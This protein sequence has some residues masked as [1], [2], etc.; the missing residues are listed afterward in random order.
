MTDKSLL[1]FII[2]LNDDFAG[3]NTT[4]FPR[5][6]KGVCVEPK[7]G[8]ALLFWHGSHPNSPMH[9]GSLCEGGT[10][11]VLRSDVMYATER[12]RSNDNDD[13]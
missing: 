11:Y 5:R 2:Y 9:E 8:S 3:G 12:T 7:K 6:S 4:F 1:T 10:K 13:D